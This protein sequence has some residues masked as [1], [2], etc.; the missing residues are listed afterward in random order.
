MNTTN[1][2]DQKNEV[3]KRSR[4]FRVGGFDGWTNG[5]CGIRACVRLQFYSY[6]EVRVG[7][8]VPLGT[9]TVNG[10]IVWGD[11]IGNWTMDADG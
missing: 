11:R 9:V 3:G 8:G 1:T 5:L 7:V 10:W 2:L 6:G 4:K